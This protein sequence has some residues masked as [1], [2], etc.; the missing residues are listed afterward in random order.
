MFRVSMNIVWSVIMTVVIVVFNKKG[1]CRL[2]KDPG[3]RPCYI[4]MCYM[5]RLLKNVIWSVNMTVAL[6][7]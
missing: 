4:C 3:D 7:V 6:L 1:S 5:F 2:I